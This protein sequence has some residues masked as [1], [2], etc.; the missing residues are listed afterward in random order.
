MVEKTDCAVPKSPPAGDHRLKLR[1][2][3]AL[4]LAIAESLKAEVILCLDHVMIESAK[5]L[6]MNVAGL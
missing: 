2:G 6:G 1:A 4:H 5:S 3:D